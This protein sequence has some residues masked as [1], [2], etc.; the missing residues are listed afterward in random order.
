MHPVTLSSRKRALASHR[1][2]DS[3]SATTALALLERATGA[4]TWTLA[5][6]QRQLLL[7]AQL[8]DLLELPATP[9]PDW[10]RFPEIF[11]PGSRERRA[12]ALQACLNH[13]TAFDEEVQVLTA[14]GRLLS[15][16]ALGQAVH[17]V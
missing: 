15:V 3:L 12:A 8:A 9:A 16:R 13:G 1:P 5:L 17:D 4:G 7:S 11:A 2:G 14:Q 10:E 6:P